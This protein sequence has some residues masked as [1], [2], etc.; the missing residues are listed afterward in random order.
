[1]NKL[2]RLSLKRHILVNDE[3]WRYYQFKIQPQTCRIPMILDKLNIM[4]M[5]NS[6]PKVN[7]SQIL[8]ESPL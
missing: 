4:N 3:Q 2:L 5:S 1:M 7:I 6:P 8:S